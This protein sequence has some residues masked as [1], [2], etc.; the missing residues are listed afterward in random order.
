MGKRAELFHS[1][2]VFGKVLF[3]LFF[4]LVLFS[5]FPLKFPHKKVHEL[6]ETVLE[7]LLCPGSQGW[8]GGG[9][10]DYRVQRNAIISSLIRSR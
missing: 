9:H 6:V 10:D 1:E 3:V 7:G 5:S 4:L 8:G 2:A